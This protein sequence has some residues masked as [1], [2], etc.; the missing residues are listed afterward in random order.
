MPVIQASMPR[1]RQ[2]RGL[3]YVLLGSLTAVLTSPVPSLPGAGTRPSPHRQACSKGSISAAPFTLW[4]LQVEGGCTSLGPNDFN[5]HW[6][7]TLNLCPSG[8]LVTEESP[9]GRWVQIS[10]VTSL[11]VLS[12]H[13]VVSGFSLRRSV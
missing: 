6:V 13:G 7:Q 4:V 10:A 8:P 9:P 11:S 12:A 3:Q 1:R 5:T 2:A